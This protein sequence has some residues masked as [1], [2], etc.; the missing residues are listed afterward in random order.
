MLINE[1][2]KRLEELR[3]QVG[4]AEV[5]VRN[6]AGDFDAVEEAQVVNISLKPGKAKWRVFLEV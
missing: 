2:I 4:D 1:L 3:A 5:E 6:S